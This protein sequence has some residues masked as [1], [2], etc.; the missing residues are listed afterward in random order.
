MRAEVV[1]HVRRLR[2]LTATGPRP[3]PAALVRD[4]RAQQTFMS[5]VLTAHPELGAGAAAGGG[6]AATI[7]RNV[8]AYLRFLR[9]VGQLDD[10][11]GKKE[12]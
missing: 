2:P 12:I 10:N 7:E 11:K 4:V 1:S 3:S 9:L 8:R 6:A 5:K